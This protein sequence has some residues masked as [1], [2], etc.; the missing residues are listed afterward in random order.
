M[1]PGSAP[2][3]PARPSGPQAPGTGGG[4]SRARR[5]ARGSTSALAACCAAL[6]ALLAGCGIRST[7]VPVD[8]GPAPSR[9]ACAPPGTPSSTD[10]D[11][12]VDRIYLVCNTQVT[13]VRRA[14]DVRDGRIDRI[15]EV[16]TLLAQLQIS[17]RT[18]ETKAGFSTAVPGTLQIVAAGPG[19]P[20]DAL[21][22]NDRPQDLP[23]FA[24]AQLVCTLTADSLVSPD[25]SVV[26]G[27]PEP[28]GKLRAY[29]CTSDL[30]TRSDSAD[31]A[32]T[33]VG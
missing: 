16:R 23:S 4:R 24:L 21:L 29:T 12:M 14:V 5:A 10:Q 9:V 27:G 8:D 26:L 2:A 22:L 15:G 28:D 6:A 31:S 32:G 7:T 1:T 18:A 19:G 17:P 25:H 30:R 3:N 33:P 20:E 13:P 11:S